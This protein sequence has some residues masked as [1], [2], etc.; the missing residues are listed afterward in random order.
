MTTASGA[1]ATIVNSRSC[2]TGY[3]Q[4]VEA[5]GETG[6]L[7]TVN[8]PTSNVRHSGRSVSGA[9][10]PYLDFFLER[11]AAAYRS[12]LDAFLRFV[13]EGAA[14][15]P[16]IFDGREALVLADAATRSANTGERVRVIPP[17]TVKEPNG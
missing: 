8:Q 11:Y 3:D 5:F 1:V 4:R 10:G 17:P 13:R 7:E 6:S 9:A 14:P 16:S 2:A 15:T 12:E